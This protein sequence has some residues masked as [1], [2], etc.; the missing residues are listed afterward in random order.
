MDSP[1]VAQVTTFWHDFSV[2]MGP[3]IL[4]I[5]LALG[6][7]L[8][9][10]VKIANA[11]L[12]K[13]LALQLIE[14]AKTA[15]TELESQAERTASKLVETA[16]AEVTATASET[17]RNAAE[18]QAQIAANSAAIEGVKSELATHKATCPNQR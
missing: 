5:A 18:L 2:A 16:I 13:E 15:A 17:L 12:Q 9:F 4:V 1:Q 3:M 10:K 8:Y 6:H 11:K 7:W 14:N